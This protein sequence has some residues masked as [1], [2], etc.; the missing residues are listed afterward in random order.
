M[1]QISS[2]YRF[3]R[4]AEAL[5]IRFCLKEEIRSMAVFFKDRLTDDRLVYPFVGHEKKIGKFP[6]S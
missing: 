2:L 6:C 3:S 5:N 4:Y 1:A